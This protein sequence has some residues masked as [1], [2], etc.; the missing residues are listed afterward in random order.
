MSIAV[1]ISPVAVF[2]GKF[3]GFPEEMAV[4]PSQIRASAAES[5]ET[6]KGEFEQHLRRCPGMSS[7]MEYQLGPTCALE[8]LF[9][10]LPRFLSRRLVQWKDDPNH[11]HWQSALARLAVLNAKLSIVHSVRNR[12]ELKTSAAVMCGHGKNPH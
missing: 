4:R 9:E 5:A 11:V 12:T 6:Q 8:A 1:M 2:P 3:K 7:C 10:S